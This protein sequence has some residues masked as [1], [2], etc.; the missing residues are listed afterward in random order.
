MN[1]T[2]S[3]INIGGDRFIPFY[4]S[5]LGI[6]KSTASSI[7]KKEEKQRLSVAR[8]MERSIKEGKLSSSYLDPVRNM[9]QQAIKK[10]NQA[11]FQAEE[12]K[13]VQTGKI[14]FIIDLLIPGTGAPLKHLA[15][16]G[17]C[18]NVHAHAGVALGTREVATK[19]AQLA[20]PVIAAV[21]SSYWMPIVAP[22][23]TTTSVVIGLT[24]LTGSALTVD[25]IHYMGRNQQKPL[26]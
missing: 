22:F 7:N 21:T 26:S 5:L 15:R 2:I 20:F 18:K 8:Q 16:A 3:L 1:A 6:N 24:A 9:K 25:A 13:L 12:H 23:M 19:T 14:A 17:R 4:D 11:S 10:L